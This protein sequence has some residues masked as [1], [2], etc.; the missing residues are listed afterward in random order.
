MTLIRCFSP[1]RFSLIGSHLGRS[2]GSTSRLYVSPGTNSRKPHVHS[3]VLTAPSGNARCHSSFTSPLGHSGHCPVCSNC[4]AASIF[5]IFNSSVRCSLTVRSSSLM[6]IFWVERIIR[7]SIA[8]FAVIYSEC[9]ECGGFECRRIVLR[10]VARQ[11]FVV[12]GS[13]GVPNSVGDSD[14]KVVSFGVFS[15]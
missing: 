2:V 11:P 4:R 9:Y 7:V 5:P 8:F 15:V 1:G 12:K 6:L 10:T 14:S 3:Y 13:S